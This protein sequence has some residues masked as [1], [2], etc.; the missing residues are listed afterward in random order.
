MTGP[1]NEVRRLGQ[2]I[3]LDFISRG[4]IIS[5]QLKKLVE[6]GLCGMTSNPTIFHKAVTRST[7][8][9]K[10][11]LYVDELIGPDKVNTVPPE[12]LETFRDHARVRRTIDERIEEVE[13]VIKLA[14]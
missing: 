13:K 5:G 3:W 10:A 11:I 6:D 12:T 4:L 8:Y 9:D 14:R 2:S 1:I 7:D